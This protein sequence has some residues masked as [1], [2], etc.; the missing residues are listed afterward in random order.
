MRIGAL[1][2]WDGVII[3][4]SRCHEKSWDLLAAEEGLDLPPGHFK[5]GFGMR[6]EH[7]IP[8]ILRWSD[9]RNE[10]SRLA[11]RKEVLYRDIVVKEGLQPLPG[12]VEFLSVLQDLNIP[13]AIGSSTPRLNI[14]VALEPLGINEYFGGIV[15][16]DDVSQG[17]PH[18]EVFFL[19]AQ[20][21]QCK[22]DHCI[23]FED[24]PVGIAAAHNG[25]M[26]AVGI[27]TTHPSHALKDAEIV[28]QSFN[29]LNFTKLKE[30]F[31]S[32]DGRA[33]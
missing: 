14:Q 33:A 26:K 3:D 32:D 9:S 18:P 22:P 24:A 11:D 23:V 6:N 13:C 28:V 15:C 20:L 25:G 5:K 8:Q 29:E 21:I 31:H 19:A 7:I 1:F 12:V 2:D 4:S 16:G 17:K 30:L 27:A 10:I